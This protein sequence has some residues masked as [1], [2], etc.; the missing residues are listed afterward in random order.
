LDD[1]PLPVG[2]S[3]DCP[4]C[5]AELRVC[6]L[7]A[8]FDQRASNQ[9]REPQA[10]LVREKERANFCDYFKPRAPEGQTA[11]PGEQARAGLEALFGGRAG[12]AS[13]QSEDAARQALDKLFGKK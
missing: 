2:R 7:C 10:E 1:L 12:A 9:C 13:P 3:A 8:F 6:R 4:Q 11:P 5:R